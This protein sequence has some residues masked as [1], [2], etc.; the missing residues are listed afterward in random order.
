[1]KV[2]K[3]IRDALIKL[4]GDSKFV[5]CWACRDRGQYPFIACHEILN[6]PL[7][8]KTVNEPC[9]LLVLCWRCNS[10]EFTNKK[11]WPIPRQL[12]LLQKWNPVGYDLERFNW[13]RNPDAPKYVEQWEVDEYK[14]GI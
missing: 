4:H 5:K 7:R 11:K 14:E 3:P 6:G 13:L 8:L 12:A 10:I 2:A 1:M 9:S